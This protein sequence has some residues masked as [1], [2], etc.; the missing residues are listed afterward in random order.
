MRDV[1]VGA[2]IL[3]SVFAL[4][5]TQV[6]AVHLDVREKA[7]Y[8]AKSSLMLWFSAAILV[9]VY[10][11]SAPDTHHTLNET[12][13]LVVVTAVLTSGWLT[14]IASGRQTQ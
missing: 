7:A 1:V 8:T 3:L 4:L 13:I 5:Y 10:L 14:L 9:G 11:V 2:L 12:V 6:L